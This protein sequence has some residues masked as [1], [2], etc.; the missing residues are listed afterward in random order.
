MNWLFLCIYWML[1]FESQIQY[2]RL[3]LSHISWSGCVISE[4][5]I[6]YYNWNAHIYHKITVRIS[7]KMTAGSLDNLLRTFPQIWHINPFTIPMPVVLRIRML[8]F[9]LKLKV[10]KSGIPVLQSSHGRCC[11]ITTIRWWNYTLCAMVSGCLPIN[12]PISYFRT[13]LFFNECKVPFFGSPSLRC[14]HV[15]Q[16]KP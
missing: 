13:V 12:F 14:A 3:C 1:D 8:Y 9:T 16:S 10:H 5:L 2:I 7:I 4:I 15:R 6:L 11:H